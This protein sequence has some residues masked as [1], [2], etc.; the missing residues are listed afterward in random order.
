MA[1][2]FRLLSVFSIPALSDDYFRF[3]WDGKM[4]MMGLNP[5]L[6]LPSAFIN[7]HAS[8]AYLRTLFNGMNS[9]GYFTVYPPVMQ[10]IFAA[11]AWLSPENITG[12]VVIF[13][14]VCMAAEGGT[15][16]LLTALLSHFKLPQKNVLWYAFNPLVIIELSGNLHFEGVMI[17]FFLLAVYLLV[18]AVKTIDGGVGKT[19]KWKFLMSS[20]SYGLA[21]SVKL[22]PLLFLPFFIKRLKWNAVIF[23][24]LIAVTVL[25][26]FLP[27]ADQL[28]IKNI[29]SSIDLYFQKFEFNASIYYLVR[30]AG[31]KA[32]GYNIVGNAGPWLALLVFI[33]VMILMVRERKLQLQSLFKAMQWSLMIYLLFA[34]TVHPW[35]IVPLI[36]MSVITGSKVPVIWSLFIIF[37]YS[38]YQTFPYHENLWLTAV[39]YAA[40]GIAMAAELLMK[41]VTTNTSR[42]SSA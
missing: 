41:G 19:D 38:A 29:G 36:A 18:T 11:A 10:L 31:Y 9:Q 7:S 4:T 30:F 40:V 17:F 28:L 42:P 15:L 14:L 21:V 35:Y 22:I 8:D 16:L 26:L 23:Y 34:T 33:L 39:E 5:Y 1:L 25:L 13:H 37:S 2:L 12:S 24:V 6:Q 20:V 32:A 27:F 3:I